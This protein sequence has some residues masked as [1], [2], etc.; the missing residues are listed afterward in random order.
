MLAELHIHD[1]AIIEKLSLRFAK[2]FNVITGETGAG[3]SILI[4][5]V[6]FALGGRAETGLIRAEAERAVVTLIFHVPP[7]LQAEI[8]ALID[9]EDLGLQDLSILRMTREIRETGRSS[10]KINE[11][12]VKITAYR[13]VGN[14]LL[15]IHGQTEHFSLLKPRQHLYLLD[16]FAG[17]DDL[18]DGLGE[19][20]RKVQAIRQTLDSLQRND[21]ERQQ[22]VDLLKYQLEEIEAAAL[23]EGEEESLREERA[24]LANSEKIRILCQEAY[25]TLDSEDEYGA[26]GLNALN[27][28][29]TALEKLASLDESLAPQ[30]DLALS[31]LEQAEDLRDALRRYQQKV[32]VSPK[33]L[34]EVE[35][36]LEVINRLKRKYGSSIKAIL[37]TAT[38]AREELQN[39][40]IGEERMAELREEEEVL[41]RSIGGLAQNISRGRRNFGKQLAKRIEAQL[42]DLRMENARFAVSMRTEEDPQGCYMDDDTRLAFDQTGIDQL[43]FQLSANAGEPLRP[44]AQVASG[45]EMARIM[46]ALKTVLS[47]ADHTPTL[48]FDEI[49]QGIGGRLGMTVG[50]KLWGLS[51]KHQVLCVT[52]LGQIAAFADAHF[53][54]RKV[55]EA[56]RTTTRVAPLQTEDRVREIAEMLGSLSESSLQNAREL[57]EQAQ[58]LRQG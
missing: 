30:R 46:L 20:V 48:I 17:L 34:N 8:R 26:S 36:R 37:E 12:S 57:L 25:N 4:D 21:R 24:R 6:D 49:D 29:A 41:L 55:T 56:Q 58:K 52:H 15:D 40:E 2:G 1:F 43:E 18:R 54:V 11:Q 42:K 5:A 38:Q 23:K 53:G 50:Q 32:E 10:A 47:E 22:R 51:D 28:V 3:K 14:L 33:R 31:L 9:A 13:E 27:V 45:G 19:Q 7:V 16:R 44:L 35:E 39:L